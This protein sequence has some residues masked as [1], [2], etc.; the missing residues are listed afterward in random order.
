MSFVARFAVVIAVAC[1]LIGAFLVFKGVDE[2]SFEGASTAVNVGA[3]P[4]DL[5][6]DDALDA[7]QSAADAAGTAIVKVV[8]DPKDIEHGRIVYTFSDHSL[9]ESY[10]AFSRSFKTTVLP[11]TASETVDPRGIYLI[12]GDSKV[13]Q[14]VAHTLT[15]AG[16]TADTE[17]RSVA[18][19]TLAQILETPGLLPLI[20]VVLAG[21]V[22][23]LFYQATRA[24]RILALKT[25]HGFSEFEGIGDELAGLAR[26]IALVALVVAGVSAF[27]LYIY[28]GL[29]QFG[30]FVWY[31][32]AAVIIVSVLAITIYWAALLFLP[33]ARLTELLKGKKPM[34]YLASIAVFVQCLMTFTLYSALVTTSK[35]AEVAA[36]ASSQLEN[37]RAE[38]DLITLRFN[39]NFTEAEFQSLRTPF[40][41]IVRQK[42][43]AGTLVLASHPIDPMPG[44]YGPD[45]GNSL[46]IN[47]EY[48]VRHPVLDEGGHS[49][50]PIQVQP[51]TMTLLIPAPLADRADEIVASFQTTADFEVQQSKDAPTPAKVT[52]NTMFTKAGQDVF[53]YGGTFSMR[54]TTQ[55]DPVIAV[56]PAETGILSSA[57]YLANATS[58]GV[59]LD[60]PESTI[61]SLDQS[62]I[63]PY[64]ASISTASD[65]AL[66]EIQR[67]ELEVRGLQAAIGLTLVLLVFT[68]GVLVA[69]YCEATKHVLFVRFIHGWP[70]WRIH[71]L[72]ITASTGILVLTL[73]FAVFASGLVPLSLGWAGIVLVATMGIT[74]FFLK[75]YEHRFRAD[76]IKRA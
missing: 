74:V 65:Y 45:V 16:F 64:L 50:G 76:L 58:G 47:N 2:V 9:T 1:S 35:Q 59:L 68:I 43:A 4:S 69:T 37:W 52:I 67:L 48:L 53:N 34:V 26:F 23:A 42:E 10:D 14:S 56:I 30:A 19:F 31:L 38:A 49:I 70:F 12:Y 5:S 60:D 32:A 54:E 8:A 17:S 73:G 44:E 57:Y 62:G 3:V 13:G 51:Y 28:N 24:R 22:L 27:A 15:A 7:V 66:A 36:S 71:A 33:N 63:R 75:L 39:P 29:A 46:T 18:L 20:V 21:L 41:K 72:Y 25:V 40:E 55:H 11:I 61:R 6:R